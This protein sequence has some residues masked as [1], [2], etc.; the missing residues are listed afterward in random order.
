M[1][2]IIKDRTLPIAGIDSCIQPG[3]I[4]RD[5]D[6]PFSDLPVY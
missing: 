1:V 6:E 3:A 4:I 5:Q 2:Q